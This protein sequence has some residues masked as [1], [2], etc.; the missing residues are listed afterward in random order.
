MHFFLYPCQMA[1]AAAGVNVETVIV[2]KDS[3]LAKD[4]A[5]K[6][7]K[8]HGS[9]PML[10]TEDGK[11]IFESVAICAYFC[12]QGA[13]ELMGAN[14]FAN[15][16]VNQWT[17]FTTC[18]MD[19][20]LRGV[21]YNVFGFADTPE[22]YDNSVKALG[23]ILAMMN[24]YLEGKQWFAGDKMSL[25]DIIVWGAMSVVMTFTVGKD[26]Q[27]LI[28]NVVAWFNAMR[29]M[30]ITVEACGLY[31][32][33]AEAFVVPGAT[34]KVNCAAPVAVA[35]GAAD[36]EEEMDDLFASEDEDEAAAAE[37][38][39][40]AAMLRGKA[41]EA[42]KKAA[43]EAA[44]KAPL[45]AKSL[46]IWEVKPVDDETDLQALGKRIIA[47]AMDGLFWKTEF[48]TAPIAYGIEKLIIGATIID[49]KVSTDD[50]QELIEEMEDMVQSVDIQSFNK[51]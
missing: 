45:E 28:P 24:K 51:L 21:V 35:A 23:P 29:V 6:A 48:K 26:Q 46:I 36:E 19:S 27:A 38:K 17:A 13:P 14:A 33:A 39:D 44:G 16:Q 9:F 34:E 47:I 7:K 4:P 31:K 1:A 41:F 18:S 42:K 25:A 10:E 20:I 22:V 11:I 49:A 3:E 32:L 15:A 5:F 8:A 12:R 30:D 40:H 43:A 50:V 37:A 2:P